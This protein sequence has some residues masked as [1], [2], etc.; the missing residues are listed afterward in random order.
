MTE[1]KTSLQLHEAEIALCERLSNIRSFQSRALIFF[2]V[3]YKIWN[4]FKFGIFWYRFSALPLIKV[5][6]VGMIKSTEADLLV[7]PC[8]QFTEASL[9]CVSSI[10]SVLILFSSQGYAVEI[11]HFCI[12]TPATVTEAD[13]A[14]P[15]SEQ[16]LS[17]RAARCCSVASLTDA[18]WAAQEPYD[19]K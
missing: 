8:S 2:P 4:I 5:N 17:G 10:T 3:L 18:A 19:H 9:K 15:A 13:A 11:M 14:K 7:L 6:V 12:S 16:D 1:T